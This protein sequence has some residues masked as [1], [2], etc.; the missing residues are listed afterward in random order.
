M[1]VGTALL[2]N[3][4]HRQTPPPPTKAAPLVLSAPAVL[5]TGEIQRGEKQ[6]E[7]RVPAIIET[8]SPELLALARDAVKACDA[9]KDEDVQEWAEQLARDVTPPT[10]PAAAPVAVEESRQVRPNRKGR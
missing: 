7:A 6:A 1:L 2:A 5:P 4:R 10:P 8:A 9:R 3:S